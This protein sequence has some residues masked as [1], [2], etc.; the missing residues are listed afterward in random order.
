MHY[1][2]TVEGRVQGV[3]YRSL[4]KNAATRFG[5]TGFVENLEDREKVCIECECGERALKE[6]LV[7][8][9]QKSE[10]FIGPNVEKITVEKIPSAGGARAVKHRDFVMRF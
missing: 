4:V 9:N 7:V 2:I 1:R 8:L 3:G 6:F 10:S 5:I